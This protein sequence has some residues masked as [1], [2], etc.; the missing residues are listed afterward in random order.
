MPMT[1]RAVAV[2]CA[3]VAVVNGAHP[4]LHGVEGGSLDMV[5]GYLNATAADLAGRYR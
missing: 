1:T 4:L 2:F 5:M 3:L